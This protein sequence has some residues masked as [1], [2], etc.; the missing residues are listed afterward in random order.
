M[1]AAGWFESDCGGWQLTLSL[2]ASKY[3]ALHHGIY[4]TFLFPS[5][6]Y[7]SILRTSPKCRSHHWN[8][9]ILYAVTKKRVLCF[10]DDLRSLSWPIGLVVNKFIRSS[11]RTLCQQVNTPLALKL[12]SSNFI[13]NADK[14][15]FL[16]RFLHFLHSEVE[17]K[18]QFLP[19]LSSVWGRGEWYIILDHLEE[20]SSKYRQKT[21]YWS[22]I[23]EKSFSS[24]RN[25]YIS[26]LKD[27]LS[28]PS[29]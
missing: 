8:R 27:P 3:P 16:Y 21:Q 23:A 7:N 4:M 9:V 12:I 6:L 18:D 15:T 24:S 26:S 19:I 28:Q 22:Q 10:D 25:N 1:L 11:S 5:L 14:F 29:K 17:V 13:Q 2:T 20:I